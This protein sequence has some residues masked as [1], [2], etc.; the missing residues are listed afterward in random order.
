[1]ACGNNDVDLFQDLPG[2]PIST[3]LQPGPKRGTVPPIAFSALPVVNDTV[4][5]EQIA[6]SLSGEFQNGDI[7]QTN[8]YVPFFEDP[9]ILAVNDFH[10]K[11]SEMS[12]DPVEKVCNIVF[13]VNMLLEKINLMIGAVIKYDVFT[14][15]AANNRNPLCLDAQIYKMKIQEDNEKVISM[16][17]RTLMK[18]C[19]IALEIIAIRFIAQPDFK[20]D[21]KMVF[22]L[23]RLYRTLQTIDTCVKRKGYSETIELVVSLIE[24]A[25]SLDKKNPDERL[26][27]WHKVDSFITNFCKH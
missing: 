25:V 12:S 2:L 11:Q 4:F 27:F 6:D 22:I 20:K 7:F 8:I 5:D 18:E 19:F 1:M 23:V 17:G 16:T 13:L 21:Y 14:I 15:L 9:Y 3:P 10:R 24:T 26:H